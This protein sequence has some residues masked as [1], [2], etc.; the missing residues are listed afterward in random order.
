[1]RLHDLKESAYQP[2]ESK[3]IILQ[4]KELVRHFIQPENVIF[5][6]MQSTG[7][8]I[9]GNGGDL[10]RRSANTS[11]YYTYLM[12]DFLPAWEN[13]PARTKSFICS[14]STEK[15]NSYGSTY[16]VIPMSDQPIAVCPQDDIWR[17]FNTKKFLGN[18]TILHNVNGALRRVYKA[19]A[20]EQLPEETATSFSTA[21]ALLAKE[22]R[23]NPL[24][25]SNFTNAMKAFDPSKYAALLNSAFVEHGVMETLEDLFDPTSNGFKLYEKASSFSHSPEDNKEVWLSGRVLFINVEMEEELMEMLK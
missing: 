8:I 4:N 18:Q 24:T 11:N 17:S 2:V 15:S 16:Y 9:Y 14:T 12:D 5:R 1:M 19:Y 22:V 21:M 20:G 10:D 3:S 23:E 13:Y 25:G 7:N 6:G